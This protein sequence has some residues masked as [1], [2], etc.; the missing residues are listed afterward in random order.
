MAQAPLCQQVERREG[1][2]RVAAEHHGG[3]DPFRV[4]SGHGG[5]ATTG[6]EPVLS[7]LRDLEPNL[8]RWLEGMEPTVQL[9]RE[10]FDAR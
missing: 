2:L 4:A 7:P 5:K 9:Y 10:A 3:L 8:R 6:I 1:D